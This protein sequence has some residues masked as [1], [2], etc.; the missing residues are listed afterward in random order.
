M[1]PK[2]A[3][4]RQP[5][6]GP[7]QRSEWIELRAKGRL[8]GRWHPK[9]QTIEFARRDQRVT[10]HLCGCKSDECTRAG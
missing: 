3:I 2:T 6:P 5:Q 1:I 10:F 8:W 9:T 4:P 7:A